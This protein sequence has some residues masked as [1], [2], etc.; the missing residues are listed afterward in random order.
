MASQIWS[1]RSTLS[2]PRGAD[3]AHHITTGTPEFS[4][5]PTALVLKARG[6]NEP[7]VRPSDP[8]HQSPL[9]N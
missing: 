1:D 8:L 9:S 3:Y 2:E 6:W 5:L 7:I 4:D